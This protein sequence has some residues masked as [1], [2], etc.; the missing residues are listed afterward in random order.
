[1]MEKNNYGGLFVAFEGP[2]GVGKSMLIDLVSAVLKEKGV[3]VYVTKEPSDTIIGSFVRKAAESIE[4]DSL[5]C[6]VAADRYYHLVN[7]II[8]NLTKKIVVIT[9]RYVLSSLVL[10]RIDKVDVDFILSL[11]QNVILPD[12]QFVIMANPAII[13]ERL[14]QRKSLT[15]FEYGNRTSQEIEFFK[16]GVEILDDFNVKSIMID[17]YA[18]LEENVIKIAEIILKVVK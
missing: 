7:D 18:N 15:R 4:G 5:A 13:Q 16:E 6:L 1:M 2:N 12:I 8:P 3:E 14:K 10:Q 9:D 17:N 11:N